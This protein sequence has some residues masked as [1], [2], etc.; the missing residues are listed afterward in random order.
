MQVFVESLETARARPPIPNW[1]AIDW[2]C[3]QPAFQSIL[4]EGAEIEATMNDAEA[5]ANEAL[6]G[7]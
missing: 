4:L 6:A 5:C 3:L 7:G 1:L 2:D